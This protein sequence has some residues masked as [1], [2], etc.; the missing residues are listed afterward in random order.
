[1]TQ[2]SDPNVPQTVTRVVTQGIQGVPGP[3]GPPAFTPT[4]ANQYGAWNGTAFVGEGVPFH[5]IR[6]D[7]PSVPFLSRRDCTA[8]VQAWYNAN[9]TT[10][11]KLRLINPCFKTRLDFSAQITNGVPINIDF[12]GELSFLINAG[13]LELFDKISLRG[14]GGSG[15]SDVAGSANI[16]AYNS[17]GQKSEDDRLF[18]TS[19]A[20]LTGPFY[21][22]QFLDNSLTATF[23]DSANGQT[24]TITSGGDGSAVGTYVVL[25]QGG[26]GGSYG[27]HS[28]YALF[29]GSGAP[30]SNQTGL[31]WTFGAQSGITGQIPQVG[32]VFKTIRVSGLSSTTQSTMLGLGLGSFYKKHLYIAN[33][34]Q[35]QLNTRYRVFG[36]ENV[37]TGVPVAYVMHYPVQDNHGYAIPITLPEYGVGGSSGA[38]TLEYIFVTSGIR[39][40]GTDISVANFSMRTFPG[41]GIQVD[42]FKNLTARV[43]IDRV[44]VQTNSYPSFFHTTPLEVQGFE[45]F[46]T[47]S[48][49]NYVQ[50]PA[51][52]ITN[53]TLQ[54][55]TGLVTFE[56]C[57]FEGGGI[58]VQPQG[59]PVETEPLYIENSVTEGLAGPV[60]VHDPRAGLLDEISI[61]KVSIADPPSAGIPVV[62]LLTPGVFNFASNIN[63]IRLSGDIATSQ[64][65]GP[66]VRPNVLEVK[67]SFTQEL[68]LPKVLP[69]ATE[70]TIEDGGRIDALSPNAPSSFAPVCDFGF[71]VTIPDP[72]TW[73]TLPGGTGTC[74]VTFT[75][76]QTGPNRLANTASDSFVPVLGGT[77]QRRLAHV[78]VT[79]VV[80]DYVMVGVWVQSQDPTQLVQLPEF[81][82]NWED[83]NVHFTNGASGF[84]LSDLSGTYLGGHWQH[85]TSCYKVA[86]SPDGTPTFL[87][88]F[89]GTASGVSV[90]VYGYWAK[91]I[92]TSAA[93][94]EHEIIRWYRQH[95][96]Y[97]VPGASAG[98]LAIDR[99]MRLDWGGRAQL[100]ATAGGGLQISGGATWYSGAGNPNGVV[101]GNLGDFY[102]NTL[103]G[104]G[105]TLYAKESGA[106]GSTSGWVGK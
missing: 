105:T 66:N 55:E 94:P 25:S 1:M 44:S 46:V 68:S 11:G 15:F 22:V 100:G 79:P 39:I 64:L 20:A 50:S 77:G 9:N 53:Y 67:T 84:G 87:D 85:L 61:R 47:N 76:G 78:A 65:V 35:T 3:T 17:L 37:S 27:V 24:F 10:G 8:D 59:P 49:F 43:R 5:V 95:A 81:A 72:S 63:V 21:I 58:L 14:D 13:E 34:S 45:V 103:G 26:T 18:A 54:A 104:S 99:R 80:G 6:G 90:A 48:I 16:V 33:S 2:P 38:P 106:A 4:Q 40:E 92:P 69:L 41:F 96:R 98:N 102:L 75:T 56:R 82:A 51:A 57:L 83:T 28:C 70:Y 71:G 62:D 89:A 12:Q 32:G 73:G 29:L 19:G 60:V 36:A 30:G 88:F 74:T 91:Y 101:A 52:L 86:Y 93:I 7:D 42:S 23:P 97:Q 31:H